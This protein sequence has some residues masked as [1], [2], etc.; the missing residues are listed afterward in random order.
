[1]NPELWPRWCPS[2]AR[3][4]TSAH[5]VLVAVTTPA[6]QVMTRLIFLNR[7]IDPKQIGSSGLENIPDAYLIPPSGS[8]PMGIGEL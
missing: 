1:M 4:A 2:M 5:L 6:N 8:L 7:H 3:A